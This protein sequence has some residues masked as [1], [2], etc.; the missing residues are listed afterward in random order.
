MT[1]RFI[2]L[3]ACVSVVCIEHLRPCANGVRVKFLFLFD[4]DEKDAHVI[5]HTLCI[6]QQQYNRNL[7]VYVTWRWQ[8]I[9]FSVEGCNGR[10]NAVHCAPLIYVFTLVGMCNVYVYF[11]GCMQM[12]IERQDF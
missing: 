9:V 11:G 4:V 10:G 2:L 5:G 6:Q 8:T 1:E 7:Y 3:Y 12:Q